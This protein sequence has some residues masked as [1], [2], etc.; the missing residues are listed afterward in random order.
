MV[1]IQCAKSSFHISFFIGFLSLIGVTTS[2]QR[3]PSSIRLRTAGY[4]LI[5]ASNHIMKKTHQY[6]HVNQYLQT[7][8]CEGISLPKAQRIP[9][10]QQSCHLI[11]GQV[12]DTG[13]G[14]FDVS[15]SH[16]FRN[17]LFHQPRQSP[18]SV[19]QPNALA[20]P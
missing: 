1:H 2:I 13:P 19:Y 11:Y 9:F 6:G 8:V 10:F 7:D 16:G 14:E 5:L 15:R 12:Q 3:Q 20:C 18:V 17:S 4:E